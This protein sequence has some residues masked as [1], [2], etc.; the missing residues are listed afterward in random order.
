MA[1]NLTLAN[2][3]I[4]SILYIGLYLVFGAPYIMSRLYIVRKKFT[5]NYT[6]KSLFITKNRLIHAMHKK[7]PVHSLFHALNNTKKIIG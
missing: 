7:R 2:Q 6:K 1:L 3:K 4:S 5:K